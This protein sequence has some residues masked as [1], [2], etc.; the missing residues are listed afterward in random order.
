ML[1][2][3]L[4]GGWMD[5]LRT[6]YH[7]SVII[8]LAVMASL[9]V[10]LIVV[11]LIEDGTIALREQAALPVITL[12]RIRFALLGIAVI[13]VLLVRPIARRVLNTGGDRGAVRDARSRPEEAVASDTG[14]LATAAVITYALCEVPAIFGLVLFVLGRDVSDFYLFLI[15]S[16]LSFS[17]HFPKFSQWEEWSR[18][19]R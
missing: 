9:V 4:S 16:L 12:E 19:R 2:G 18:Q 7:V 11:A 5:N 1:H 15:I 6:A 10:Y 14:T 13:V 3:E 8:G 17:I